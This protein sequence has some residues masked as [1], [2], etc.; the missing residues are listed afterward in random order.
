MF[1]LGVNNNPQ[2]N[3]QPPPPSTS[4]RHPHTT[5][6]TSDHDHPRS[7]QVSPP[8]LSPPTTTTWPPNTQRS[9]PRHQATLLTATTR[10]PTP[11]THHL[12]PIAH[13]RGGP[14]RCPPMTTSLTLTITTR[15]PMSPITIPRSHTPGA[16][17]LLAMWQPNDERHQSSFIMSFML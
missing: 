15:P 8:A 7:Y 3:P 13:K 10:I 14:R 6:F 2:P 17:S 5:A 12:A 4:P 9:S 16:T 11:T 1:N